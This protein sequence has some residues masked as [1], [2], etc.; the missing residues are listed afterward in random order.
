MLRG[1][2]RLRERRGLGRDAAQ[3]GLVIIWP[4]LSREVP[5]LSS[6][7]LGDLNPSLLK[8]LVDLLTSFLLPFL[9]LSALVSH[10]FDYEHHLFN[11][12]RV[13]LDFLY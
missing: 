11:V 8:G 2:Y 3:V 5:S 12:G 4:S 13:K 1:E 10:R 7:V 6:T 9:C